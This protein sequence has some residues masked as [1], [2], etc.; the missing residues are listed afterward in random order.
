MADI[1][2]RDPYQSL[3]RKIGYSVGLE[4]LLQRTLRLAELYAEHCSLSLTTFKDLVEIE[5]K[6]KNAVQHFADFY[7][8]LRLVRLI[9][10][11]IHALHRLETLSILKRYLRGDDTAFVAAARIVLAQAILEADGDIFLNGLASDFEPQSFKWALTEMVEQKRRAIS[12]VIK[13]PSALKRVYSVIDIKNQPSHKGKEGVEGRDE[14]ASRFARRTV[15]L[16]STR[17]TS[18]LSETISNEIHVP[19]DYLRKVPATRKG[20]AQDL[21]LFVD[22][23]KTTRGTGLLDALDT[24]LRVKQDTGCY[25]MW[26]YPRELAQLRIRPEDIQAVEISPWLVLCAIAEGFS[27]ITVENPTKERDYTHVIVQLREFHQLYREGSVS[28]GSIRH[29]LPL[30]IA[31]P[32]LVAVCAAQLQPIPPLPAIIDSEAKRAFRRINRIVISGTEG[33]VVFSQ[34]R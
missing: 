28:Y 7:G 10:N 30:Y 19:D 9:G 24:S 25:I 23:R 15:P 6:R 18:L 1:A 4:H 34:E 29:Q 13:S 5:F 3:I 27:D 21:G 22:G 31:E 17:R 16:D 26:P 11:S 14:P 8:E 33:G 2:P 32:C 20:W 12:N